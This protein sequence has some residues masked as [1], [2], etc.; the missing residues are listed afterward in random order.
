MSVNILDAPEVSLIDYMGSDL[1]VVRAAKVSVAGENWPDHLGQNGRGLIKYLMTHRHGSPF[2]HATMTFFVKAPIF[3]FREFHRHRIAS[4]NEMSGRYTTLPDE[5]YLPN[6]LRPLVNIGTSAR[7]EFAPGTRE[8]FEGF[9]GRSYA[10][11]EYAWEVYQEHL[12]HGIA[13]EMARIVLPVGIYSQMY[14]TMNVR[15]TM[16]FLSLRVDSPDSAV[17]SRPQYEIQQVA[18][19]IEKEF[20]RLFPTVH[21]AF[22]ERG[23]TAP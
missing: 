13:N 4:Y 11:Y 7:P 9:I 3:V 14:V 19:Q 1:S 22:V 10:L 2:E 17:R 6:E 23:R 20:A 21:E 15:A 12:R 16:N 8:Q 18:E 5:F